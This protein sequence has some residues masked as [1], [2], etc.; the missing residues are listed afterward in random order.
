MAN[1]YRKGSKVSWKWGS[2]IAQGI[3]KEIYYTKVEKEIK[4]G[5]IKRNASAQN[6]AYYI[7][8]EKK[9]AHVL[10]LKFEL[11]D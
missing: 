3:I 11:S 9:D 4:G 7:E 6:S 10:K 2:R 1:I 8:E 5:K